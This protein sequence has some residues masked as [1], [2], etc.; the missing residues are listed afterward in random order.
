MDC[1]DVL[2][3]QNETHSANNLI[4]GSNKKLFKLGYLGDIFL[5][6]GLNSVRHNAFMFGL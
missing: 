1:L 6:K 4:D 2:N 3:C 5:V